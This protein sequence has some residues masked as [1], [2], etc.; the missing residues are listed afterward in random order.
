MISEPYEPPPEDVP[1]AV[2]AHADDRVGP[3]VG[4]PVDVHPDVD[5]AARRRRVLELLGFEHHLPYVLSDLADV[6]HPRLA[7]ALVGRGSHDRGPA[8][9]AAAHEAGSRLFAVPADVAGH[10]GAQP[11]AAA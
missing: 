1:G 2:R 11:R 4:A 10:L 7:P 3:D 5:V 8:S 9:E 6:Q